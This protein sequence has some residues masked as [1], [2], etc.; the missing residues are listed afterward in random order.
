M[1]DISQSSWAES[2]AGNTAAPPNGWPE[3]QAPSTVNDCA[4][5]M[6]GAIKRFWSRIN[7]VAASGGAANAYTLTPS[8][9]LAAYVTGEVYSFRANHTNSGAATLNI[10]GL[11]AK[12]IKKHTLAG[13]ADV[14]SG[15]LQSGQPVQVC[16]DGTDMVLQSRTPVAAVPDSPDDIGAIGQ[17]Q[18]AVC[19]TA[20]YLRATPTSGCGTLA[21]HE[22]ATNKVCFEYL[23][24]DA[25]AAEYAFFVCKAP[26]SADETAGIYVKNLAWAHPGTASNFGVSWKIQFLARSND[27]AADTAYGTAIEVADTGGTTHDIYVA[28]DSAAITPGGSWAEGDWLFGRIQRDPADADDTLAVDAWLIGFDLVFTIAAQNDA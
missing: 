2:D 8:V 4:R 19:I 15:E 13:K 10:S 14:A 18:H 21:V 22:T 9:A 26:K 1:P 28:P 3:N 25:S 5:M 16:Y 11:G 24:F 6:M 17:G 7:P 20:R 12:A 23:P 27:D